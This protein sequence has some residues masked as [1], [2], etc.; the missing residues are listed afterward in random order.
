M[1]EIMTFIQYLHI[2]KGMVQNKSIMIAKEHVPFG[3]VTGI[4]IF[5]RNC[6]IIFFRDSYKTYGNENLSCMF[7]M[8]L[9]HTLKCG[10]GLISLL[11]VVALYPCVI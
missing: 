1:K 10:F 6:V 5:E 11:C 7:S 2:L 8:R 9:T 3:F 4:F